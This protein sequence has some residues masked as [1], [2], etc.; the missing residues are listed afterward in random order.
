MEPQLRP[1]TSALTS[2]VSRASLTQSDFVL[3]SLT[4]LVGIR[5]RPSI[6]ILHFKNHATDIFCLVVL[7]SSESTASSFLLFLPTSLSRPG[8]YIHKVTFHY[9]FFFS[10]CGFSYIPFKTVNNTGAIPRNNASVNGLY[11]CY[12]DLITLQYYEGIRRVV[13]RTESAS[14]APERTIS[15]SRTLR[16]PPRLEPA[17]EELRSSL[18]TTNSNSPPPPP[19]HPPSD[20]FCSAFHLIP[21][22]VTMHTLIR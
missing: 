2:T 6:L 18:L 19:S 15:F 20:L 10:P 1:L 14:M 4:L 5:L 12:F 3:R 7:H 8:V 16:G 9:F 13:E 17:F 21:Q 22:S 11:W